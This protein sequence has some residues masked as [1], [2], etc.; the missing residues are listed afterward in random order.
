MVCVP[1]ISFQQM[2]LLFS[3]FPH[4]GM[5]QAK[6]SPLSFI[7]PLKRLQCC[8]LLQN[9]AKHYVFISMGCSLNYT[10]G[11]GKGFSA[12]RTYVAPCIIK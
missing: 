2:F 12:L 8:S 3:F 9:I 11:S 7:W 10:V 4:D 1:A 5:F 6:L